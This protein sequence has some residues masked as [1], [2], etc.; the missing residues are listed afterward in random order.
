MHS[1]VLYCTVR[2]AFTIAKHYTDVK[3]VKKNQKKCDAYYNTT[4]FVTQ[5]CGIAGDILCKMNLVFGQLE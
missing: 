3:R 1:I 2:V 4:N 5:Y